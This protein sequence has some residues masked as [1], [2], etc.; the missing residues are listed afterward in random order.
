MKKTPCNSCNAT[1]KMKQN[2]VAYQFSVEH[3]NDFIK[4][5]LHCGGFNIY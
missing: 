3:V 2:I 1:G 4:F 5:L